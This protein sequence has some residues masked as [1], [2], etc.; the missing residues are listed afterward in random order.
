MIAQTTA[1]QALRAVSVPTSKKSKPTPN[2]KRIRAAAPRYM[3]EAQAVALKVA[4]EQGWIARSVVASA[5][6]KKCTVSV[7]KEGEIA[8][9][10]S[11]GV[12]RS[13]HDI[14]KAGGLV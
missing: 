1:K 2:Q 9:I 11:D 14:I 4:G 8:W 7:E 6:H 13:E 3:T 12:V 5:K 10:D